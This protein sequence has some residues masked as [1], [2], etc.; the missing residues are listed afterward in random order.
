ML[1]SDPH[2]WLRPFYV[3]LRE[4]PSFPQLAPSHQFAELCTQVAPEHPGKAAQMREWSAAAQHALLTWLAAV[5]VTSDGKSGPEPIWTVRKNGREL[6]CVA[7]YLPT[8]IDLRLFEADDFRRTALCRDAPALKRR[9]DE[10]LKAL[11]AAGWISQSA[12]KCL[13]KL[14]ELGPNGCDCACALGFEQQPKRADH[15]DSCRLG[16]S[17]GRTIV[18][19]N[20]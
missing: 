14:I 18:E 13:E 7:V 16:Q 8:V 5:S 2:A 12:L 3:R 15:V 1:T 10:W 19:E 9:A 6:R 11:I 20:R 17:P 4:R